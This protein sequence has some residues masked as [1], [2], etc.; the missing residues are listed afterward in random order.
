MKLKKD[1]LKKTKNCMGCFS[2]R[3]KINYGAVK[4]MF[5]SSSKS[6]KYEHVIKIMET[7]SI[8]SFDEIFEINQEEKNKK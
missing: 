8:K 6:I 3:T 4:R 1:L 2:V 7:F 5:D